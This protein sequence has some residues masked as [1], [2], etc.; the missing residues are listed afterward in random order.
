MK[1]PLP[2]NRGEI[3]DQIVPVGSA[4]TAILSVGMLCKPKVNLPHGPLTYTLLESSPKSS[5]LN[6]SRLSW[7]RNKSGVTD[8]PPAK[9]GVPESG[10]PITSKPALVLVFFKS[11]NPE[12][13][14]RLP[15]VVPLSESCHP[16]VAS[17]S[18]KPVRPSFLIHTL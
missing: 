11:V 2:R 4:S 10:S 16:P 14:I 13:T 6:V 17:P 1:K 8:P 9:L 12:K 15:N 3:P 18:S 5:P 7:L